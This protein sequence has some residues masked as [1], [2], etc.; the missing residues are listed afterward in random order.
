MK[1]LNTILVLTFFIMLFSCRTRGEKNRYVVIVNGEGVGFSEF[2]SFYT[3]A[4][5]KNPNLS[6]EGFLEMVIANKLIVE[7][8]R[9][10][11][12]LSKK[13][14]SRKLKNYKENRVIFEYIEKRIKPKI[15]AKNSKDAQ[16]QLNVLV[17][18][19]IKLLR[20]RAKLTYFRKNIEKMEKGITIP[21]NTL[22][23]KVDGYELTRGMIEDKIL[24]A[25][26]KPKDR[27][28]IVDL[29]IERGI[30]KLLLYKKACLDG[31]DKLS[32][33]S[34]DIN[35]Y[36]DLLI[37]E[38]FIDQV[39]KSVKVGKDEM[40]SYYK[41]HKARY[42]SPLRVKVAHILLRDK[43]LAENLR[44]KLLGG[45]SFQEL[46][47]KFSED[48]ISAKKGGL[49]GYI[50]KGQTPLPFEDAAFSLKVGEVSRVI[51]TE[52]GY[53]IIKVLERKEPH[54]M[55]F[56]EAKNYVERDLYGE[57]VKKELQ[58]R[59]EK[60]KKSAK[61]KINKELLKKI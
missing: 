48:R 60:L 47:K 40:L 37:V 38:D 46:A 45:A 4:K 28:K 20:N 6:K 11:K 12:I 44:K 36:G 57:K 58:S 7:D 22:L 18:D 35:S 29:L 25:R 39:K 16:I 61:I 53:H 43:K 55:E 23:A 41:K 27:K 54:I 33:V 15:K 8:G 5:K 13:S 32:N 14:L 31:M 1:R 34:S 19:E 59:I 56:N 3:S 49:I 10:R 52:F 9:K 30:N 17:D 21:D 2:K 51:K 24:S 42:I 50:T 26:L